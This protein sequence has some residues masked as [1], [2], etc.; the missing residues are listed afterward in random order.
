[1]SK[2]AEINT[3]TTFAETG[4]Y[5]SF[6]LPLTLTIVLAG[7]AFLPRMNDNPTLAA[8]FLGASL[9][10]LTWQLALLLHVRRTGIAKQFSVSIQPQ[11]YVQA[12]VQFSV[13]LYWGYY[14]RPVYD[15]L[16]LLAG[17]VVFAFT[18]GILLAWS[19]RRTY[20]LG[21]GPIPIIFSTNLFLWFRDDWFYLQFLMIFV[22]F[23]GK[24]YIRW[25]R[26]GK[27][28]HIF[29][30][31][32]FG[33]GLFS[34]IL[35]FTGTTDLTWAPQISSTLTLA[36]KIYA[37]LFVAGLVVMYFFS[38]TLVSVAAALSL[39]ALS[40][41]YSMAAGVPYFLDSEIP[42]AVF[43]GLHLLIT[44]PSTS[45]RTP[46]GK[47]IFGILYGLG[48]FGLYALLDAIGQP[49][50][51]DKLLCVPL[52][53]LSVIL[54]DRAVRSSTS[55]SLTNMWNEKWFKG[56]AN[57]VH[58]G[59][60]VTIF[61]VVSL[62]GKTDGRH[63][64]DS[65]PF[66]EKSCAR[67]LVNSCERLLL[68]ETTYCNDNSA[69]ACNELG[70]HYRKGQIIVQ[71]DEVARRYFAQACELNFS[72]GCINLLNQPNIATV[73][74][75]PKDLDLRLMLRQAG[76]NLMELPRAELLKRA[77]DHNWSIRCS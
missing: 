69:W 12:M 36:P 71:N 35:I 73:H 46:L 27:N 66:W 47:T 45:P 70:A 64:G 40:S 44:D 68:I 23:L 55:E 41:L 9:L 48:V 63:T 28:S 22:G 31:S 75:P 7:M 24:E 1:M 33:L 16:W 25:H 30:P 51:Y 49:T 67:G 60:W 62:L 18:L 6:K 57:T 76:K 65:L 74:A 58:M 34:L 14:W 29:N 13:Y 20:L 42:A 11:H 32:A 26:D 38:I 15:H 4:Q 54:I 43:L 17:Q 8:S 37:Y 19:R 77:C 21:F 59:A 61:I 50:F 52:L 3:V 56:H 53:N 5:S 72:A 2:S 10:L 39:F